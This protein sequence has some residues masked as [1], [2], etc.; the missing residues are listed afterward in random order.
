MTLCYPFVRAGHMIN[1]PLTK[2]QMDNQTTNGQTFLWQSN[3]WTTRQQMDKQTTNGQTNMPLTKQQIDKQTTNGQTNIP[4][5]KQ[6]MDNQTT[7]RHA[8]DKATNGQPDNKRTN[9]HA[10]CLTKQQIDRHDFD[11]AK[12]GQTGM[13]LSKQQLDKQTCLWQM[14]KWTCL[15][16][17]NNRTN[18]HA[19]VKWTNWHAFDKVSKENQDQKKSVTYYQPSGRWSEKVFSASLRV[20]MS[21][22][23]YF[24]DLRIEGKIGSRFDFLYYCFSA[25][26]NYASNK[27]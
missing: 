15:W 7:N 21:T 26:G 5:T 17:S 23:F 6:Q 10:L 3:K 19:F 25:L 13:L 1:M 8:F 16:L 4:L 20:S 12:N 2:Q 22:A 14:E 24:A 18:R 9:R 27:H 11:T